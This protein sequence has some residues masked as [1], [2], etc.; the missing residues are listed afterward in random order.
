[1]FRDFN[2]KLIFRIVGGLLLFEGAFLLTAIVVALVHDE[3]VIR[4][5]LITSTIAVVVG[6]RKSV[7]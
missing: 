6:D 3:H 2:H 7:V 5:F 1:M 4:H